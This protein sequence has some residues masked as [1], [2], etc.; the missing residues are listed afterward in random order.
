[1]GEYKI[2][3]LEQLTGVKAHTLRIWEKRYRIIEPQRTDTDIRTYSDED[4]RK[5]LCISILNKSGYK[6]SR[7]ADMSI[8]K[9][10]ALVDNLNVSSD[11]TLYFEKLLYALVEFDENLFQSTI[12]QLIVEFG[13]PQTFTHYFIPFLNRIGVM[14]VT[15]SINPAQEHFITNLIRQKLIS[16]INLL[17]VPKMSN[18]VVILFLPESEW[19]ELGLL[20]YHYV[21]RRKGIYTVYLGQSLPYDSLLETIQKF[22]PIALVTSVLSHYEDKALVNYFQQIKQHFPDLQLFA[23]GYQIDQQIEKLAPFVIQIQSIET[24]DRIKVQS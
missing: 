1:M 18:G 24:L 7:I 20:F 14:W 6:I 23:G 16:E 11:S 2:K 13:V 12:N 4:L 15:G 22:Q 5:L 10:N 8:D 9:I 21:L 3:D 19:H 17:E